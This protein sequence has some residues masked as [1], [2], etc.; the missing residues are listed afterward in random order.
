MD[1]PTGTEKTPA[2]PT[3]HFPALALLLLSLSPVC[4]FLPVP[5]TALE[6]T[7]KEARKETPTFGLTGG[8]ILIGE[9]EEKDISITTSYGKLSVPFAEILRVRFA[10]R[11]SNEARETM[12]RALERLRGKD[13]EA[14]NDLRAIGPG[15]YGELVSLR[16]IEK[17]ES[18]RRQLSELITD[19][20]SLDDVYLDDNDEVTTGRF[21][22]RGNI[23][24]AL[25]HVRRGALKLEIP[26]TDLVYI[27]WGELDTSKTWKV[28]FSHIESA[29][30]HL[31]TGYKL[32]K[33]QKFSL[34]ASG[35]IIWQGRTFG[36][37]GLANH[38]WNNRNMGC[39]QWRVGKQAWRLAGLR[40]N[41]RSPASG[42]LQLAIHLTPA[43][44]TS[45]FFRVKL[46]SKKK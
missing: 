7:K 18:I 30:R 25:F 35:N 13:P 21:T 26:S 16:G 38:T 4:V 40:F 3:I 9:L 33:G 11:L 15:C 31:S 44:S 24:T 46:R 37:A 17:N 36:P 8:Q 23:E 45:G 27:A 1:S 34:E 32:R 2:R 41:G 28:T 29:N 10:P 6:D 42:E 14:M 12:N 22:I 39:L 20:E 19:L 5:C 43:G